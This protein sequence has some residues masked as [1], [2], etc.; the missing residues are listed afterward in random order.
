[1]QTERSLCVLFVFYKCY[2]CCARFVDKIVHEYAHFLRV[3]LSLFY[4]HD[5]DLMKYLSINL[6]SFDTR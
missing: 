1:M 5:D 4:I 6:T 3:F 2:K